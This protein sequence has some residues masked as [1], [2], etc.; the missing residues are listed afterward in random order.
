MLKIL[1]GLD[2]DNHYS[3]A[4]DMAIITRYALKTKYINDIVKTKTKTVNFGSFTKT[5]NN[6]NALLRTYEFADGVKTGFTNGANRCLIASATKDENR[7][8]AVVLGAD[9]TKTRFNDAKILLDE[10][11]KR[12]SNKDISKLLNL[13]INIPV[14]KGNIQNYERK[15]QENYLLPLTDE[16][17]ERIYIKQEIV[18][19]IYPPMV[20]GEKIGTICAYVGDEKIYSKDIFLDQNISK[21]NTLNYFVY[22]I[23]NMFNTI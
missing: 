23:K 19:K 5:L 2:S 6:T 18:N 11:F 8:I 3:T 14:E 1:I 16:E 21:K 9:T 7:Y 10:S 20:V 15:I 22:A 13:Y 17:Y 4:Y 12:Y